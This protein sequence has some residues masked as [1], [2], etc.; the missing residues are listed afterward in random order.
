VGTKITSGLLGSGV[1][2]TA[3]G[4]CVV[5]TGVAAPLVLAR[6]AFCVGLVPGEVGWLAVLA[7]GLVAPASA[8]V[9]F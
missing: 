7:A 5:D 4:V 2:A 3:G 6:G 9:A 1:A 8:P